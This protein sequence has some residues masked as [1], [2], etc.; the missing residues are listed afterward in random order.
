MAKKDDITSTEKLLE[1]IRNKG[2]DA[3]ESSGAQPVKKVLFPRRSGP[4]AGR[5]HKQTVKIGVDINGSDITLAAVLQVS[6]KKQKLLEVRRIPLGPDVEKGSNEFLQLLK[7]SIKALSGKYKHASLWA[8]ISS[9]NVETRLLKIPKVPARQVPNAV[10]WAFQKETSIKE[11]DIFDFSVIETIYSEGEQNSR[12]L[13]YTAPKNEINAAKQTFIKIGYPLEG[14]SIVPFAIQ[15]LL[16]TGWIKSSGNNV[17]TLFIGSDWSRIAIFSK[18]VLVLSRDIKAGARSMVQAILQT[19]EKKSI[20]GEDD[21]IASLPDDEAPVETA[22][23][24]LN[25]KKAKKIFAKFLEI[26]TPSTDASSDLKRSNLVFGMIKPALDRVIRQVEMTLEHF[27]LNFDSKPI[28]NVYISGELS[29]KRSIVNYIGEQLGRNVEQIDPFNNVPESITKH[30]QGQTQLSGDAFV[31]AAGMALSNNE[32]TPNFL[33]TYIHKG[34]KVFAKRFN[35]VAYTVFIVLI[36]V[37]AGIFY[38]QTELVKE[39]KARTRP[40]QMELD[41]YSPKLDSNLMAAVTGETVRKMKAYSNA[42]GYYFPAAVLSELLEITPENV[43]LTNVQAIMGTVSS[44]KIE[45]SGKILNI[46]GSVSGDS[47]SFNR[48]MTAYLIRLKKSPLFTQPTVKEKKIQETEDGEVLKFV[49]SMSI[50]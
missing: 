13:A 17:C 3:I 28:D 6:E 43:K 42:A 45:K 23:N 38:Y 48:K 41:A 24:T 50:I 40:L 18:S 31:P 44:Q 20:P 22:E 25:L 30:P 8:T 2:K 4:G 1:L 29:S 19:L 49:L 34:K 15:N 39:I 47:K 26:K 21:L 35:Q 10:K 7:S 16:R 32:T 36:C 5:R 14:I 37:A 9:A 11:S 12:I 33:F 27:G 46:V